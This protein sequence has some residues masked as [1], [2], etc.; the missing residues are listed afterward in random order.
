MILRLFRIRGGVHPPEHK[1]PTASRPIEACP[2]PARLYVPL[3]QHI[4]APAEPV[5]QVG[6][7]VLKGQ[8]IGHA[9]GPVSA[10]VHAPTSGTVTTIA[11]HA[12]PHPSG[13]PVVCVT[14][15]PDGEDRW[16]SAPAET[17]PFL[18]TPREIGER[19]AAAGIVGMGGAAFPSA[20]KLGA[21]TR[22]PIHTLII[23]G[24]ECEPYLTCDD[25]LMRERAV[26]VIDGVRIMLHGTQATRALIAIE[27]NKPSAIRELK[28]AARI[29]ERVMVVRI[30][31]L[32]PMGSEK[33]MIQTLTGR[34]LP[35][36][37]LPADLGLIVHNVA[38][39]F[40]VHRA[41]RF[42]RPLISR[43]VTV[44]GGA[45]REP[46]NR[47]VLIGT[48]IEDLVECCGGFAEEPARLLMG[49]PMMGQVIPWNAPVVKGTSGV[50]ALTREEIH[51]GET[52]A[53]IRCGRCVS[54]CPVGLMP[55]EM[56][57][58][59]RADQ[60]D[61]AVDHGLNDCISC[62]SCAF[63]CP[64]SIPLVQFFNF[65]KGELVARKTAQDKSQ[66]LKLMA[67][68]RQARLEREAREK[69]EAAARKKAERE[70]AKRA[71]Q[72]A[73]ARETGT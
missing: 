3:Q 4:G 47:E 45:L 42:G 62:G 58:R 14:I 19:V 33:H 25:R 69:A 66:V 70:A 60:F 55:L 49:G 41:V 63:V 9:Q 36:G 53:C 38:T 20:V 51:I 39:A 13:L 26:E 16:E 54:A 10:P 61:G 22:T 59:I 23:N 2:L 8:L 34:E 44:G 35:P 56:A 27:E 24:G 28:R 17:D 21:A 6:E 73:A 48:P 43:I 32:Y 72:E 50:I 68:Q 5:V 30:P 1:H 65:A 31:A 37:R 64:A 40:A 71:E 52:R 15:E 46:R 11:P 12:A 57:S 7:K 29:D 67:E 18:L